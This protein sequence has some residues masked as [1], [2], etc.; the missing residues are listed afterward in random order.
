[1][2]DGPLRIA[3]L[4]YGAQSGV[5]PQVTSALAAL[6]HRVLPLMVPGPLELR[7]PSTG[8]R[9]FTP[10][11]LLHL[12]ASAARYG[13]GALA[14]RWN[15]PYAFDVHTR[16]AG[17]LVTDLEELPDVLLQ[18]GALFAPGIP[19]SA[20]Y[21][22]LLDHTRALSMER[23][24]SPEAGLPA[25]RDYGLAWRNR[26]AAVYR[27]AR[28]IAVFSRRVA[29]SLQRDYAVPGELIHV[30]GAGANVFPERPERLD[31]GATILFVGRDFRRKG[32]P[33]LLRA[34]ER[35]RRTHPQARLVIAGPRER[36]DLPPG[37]QN[38]GPLAPGALLPLFASASVFALP[39]LREPFGIAFLDALAC[40]VPCV[41]T[42]VEAV[43]EIVEHERS[44]L[45]V[46][47]GND[48]ALA[49]ALARLLDSPA[50]RQAMG[51]YGR[52]RVAASFQ[53]SHVASRLELALLP[54]RVA[55]QKS[56]PAAS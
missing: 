35:L 21:V 13:R 29:E 4:H 17:R 53:W 7:D 12:L 42:L 10:Q 51:L 22:L 2:A 23:P 19:S 15:T 40:A 24:A 6:G 14:H 9:R 1:M 5:T 11:V 18:N 26:E 52:E 39:T 32:G 36:L 41:G 27:G 20:P 37:A 46:P 31:D 43:P 47:P 8:A 48:E 3:Y 38:L 56:L 44:G 30:V 25:P 16:R 55:A 34:F 50:E 33:V 54:G 45:L 28:A 49:A